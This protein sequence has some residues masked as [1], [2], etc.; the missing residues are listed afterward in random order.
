MQTEVS[1]SAI[2]SNPKPSVSPRLAILYSFLVGLAG[3][4]L[5]AY[6]MAIYPER[7]LWLPILIFSGLSLV[8]QRS[9]FHLG[10]SAVHSLAGVIDVAAVLALGPTPGA[11]VAALSGS[12]YLALNALRHQKLNRRSLMEIPLFNAGL[13]ALMALTGGALFQAL[14]GSLPLGNDPSTSTL[15]LDGRI[16][17]AFGAVCLVWFVL[18]HV[19]WG[20][21]DYL[22]GGQ[23]RLRLFVRNAVPNVLL[24]E[25]LPLF[26]GLVVAWV[27]AHLGWTVFTLLALAIVAVSV[28]AQRWADARNK[29]V[30]FVAE[31]STIEQVGRAITQAQLDVDELCT[32]LYEY[33]TRIVDTTI[34]HLGLFEDDGYTLKLWMREGQ[35]QPPRTFQMRPGVGLINWMRES[36]Q[37]LLVRD[38]QKEMDSLPAQ[39][40]YVADSPPRSALFVPLLAGETVIGTLSLQSFRPDAYDEGDLRVLS[41][42][43]NQAA[44]AIQKA[45]FYAQEHKRVRQL[46]TI[47]QVSRQVSAILELDE[48]FEQVVHLIREN[49][50][51]YHVAVYTADP[52]HQIVPFQASA[53]AGEQDVVFEVEWGQ[54]LIGWV[55]AHAQSVIINDVE[56]EPRYRCIEALDETQSEMAVPLLLDEKLLGVLDVQNDQ[57]NAFG[58]DDLF[59]LET[60]GSQVAVA[61]HEARLYEAERQQAWLSTAL[62][63]VA[64]AMSQ[65]SDMDAVLTTVVRLT[66]ML[67]GV[68][69]CAILLWDADTETFIPAQTH[70]LTPE[71]R[72]AFNHMLFP[73][74]SMPALD[75]LRW[76]KSPLL[77]KAHDDEPLVPPDLVETFHI[78]E[79]LLLPLLA[80]GELL[81]AMMVDFAGRAH[82]FSERTIDML[83]GIANQAAMV[84]QSAR[85][86]QAQKEEAY[87]SMALLQVAETVSRST[88]LEEILATIVRITPMLVGV[89][90][91]A[92]SLW[93]REA[94]AFLPFQQYGL[95]REAQPIFWQLHLTADRSPVR[96]L[97]GG[98]P[99]V[100][101]EDPDSELAQILNGPAS[102]ALPL[103][104]R[105]GILG[106]MLV[107]STRSQQPSQRWMN[108]LT[109][110]AGQAA[111][112]VENNHLLKEAAEQE[113]MKQELE[114][115]RQIQASFLPECCPTIPGW[116]MAAIWRSARQVG[117][118]FYDF[119]PLPPGKGEAEAE[120][121]RTGVVIADVADKGVPAAL[122][123][124][125]SRTLVRS[126]ATGGGAA[127]AT[128]GRANTLIAADARSDLFVTLFYAILP[129]VAGEVT[130]VNAGHMPPLLV[131][132]TDGTTEE[133]RTEGIALGILP[134][135]EFEQRTVH[136]D[137]GDTLILSLSAFD[138]S[139]TPSV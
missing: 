75:L 83:S 116:E 126:V 118:D 62:L 24:I 139:V 26:F 46:E 57:R 106:T 2:Q 99:Y 112:A 76:Q 115:A 14:N 110:I 117:G 11:A 1:K 91:C 122:F 23:E 31:L 60:L 25:L 3:L 47:G 96:E 90:A 129:S 4:G 127:A 114:V 51:Y 92:I 70:G 77:V 72:D 98:A 27:Y 93:D 40:A 10:S 85:L 108:I 124:A 87:V 19:G 125:L 49:F 52:E 120:Q 67:A 109:G 73:V 68:D 38:F 63:Q 69:R 20:I 137:P 105:G 17:L 101:L 86:V 50:G 103:A 12:I 54:G 136:L 89:E 66:P 61:I 100:T 6:R 78:Q 39:P 111:I 13:K 41:A 28:L 21:L 79:M 64:E 132:S 135:F 95:R 119:I 7:L 82:R 15:D 44:V 102:L 58:P 134:D 48:L 113:R 65:V 22:H 133:L 16:L 18:E 97:M 107:D 104:A 33:T 121:G 37:P 84:I 34:F 56:S 32:L 94:A 123:M 131:R 74:D 8:V 55:A 42:L 53:S 45:Q 35:M 138:A 36:K 71:L 88:D 81:G 5:L 29:L 130:Y 30:Q 128:I 59:I 9:S 80:Q 43:A